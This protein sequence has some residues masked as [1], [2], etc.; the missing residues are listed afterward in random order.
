VPA[1]ETLM[2]RTGVSDDVGGAT[3]MAA[4]GSA[5]ELFTS[6][7]G[8]FS[9]SSVGFGTI[10]GS[11]VFNVLF[12]IGMCALFSKELLTLTWW[13]L[14]RDVTYYA[15]SLVVLAAFFNDKT[16][17]L[18]EAVILFLMYGG[19][20]FLMAKNQALHQWV[21]RRGSSTPPMKEGEL[22]KEL[23]SGEST[24]G[25]TSSSSTIGPS[26]SPAIDAFHGINE[27]VPK[28]SAFLQPRTFRAGVFQLMVRD[29]SVGTMDKVRFLFAS[30]ETGTADEKFDAVDTDN[31]GDIDFS[32]FQE[33]VRTLIPDVTDTEVQN[34]LEEM[35]KDH[36]GR[37]SKAE[38]NAWYGDSQLKNKATEPSMLQ[39]VETVFSDIDT[40]NSGTVS[41]KPDIVVAACFLH[42]KFAL[43]CRLIAAKWL[44][45]CL[46]STPNW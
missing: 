20:V 19:Y 7:I 18:Y 25:R 33:L 41:G 1:L 23:E 8:T 34:A 32:E 35:D 2:K 29:S 16:I 3:F 42:A 6:L 24:V 4:G 26:S 27:K 36:D 21:I 45:S 5:P 43:S 30:D 17:E 44:P 13:P 14:A 11:A 46:R 15:I 40:N 28:L 31:S 9:E 37:V 10:V 38:F 12:V 22:E 39:E